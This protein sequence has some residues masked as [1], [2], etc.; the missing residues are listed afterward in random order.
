MFFGMVLIDYMIFPV[1]SGSER[2][3]GLMKRPYKS[4]KAK[5]LLLDLIRHV[6]DLKLDTAMMT[7]FPGETE[8][9]FQD[10]IRF[11]KDVCFQHIW[12]YE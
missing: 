4:A 5:E 10:T 9:D 7:G 12:I 11:V 3:L 2:I 6:R 1:Q 8:Q